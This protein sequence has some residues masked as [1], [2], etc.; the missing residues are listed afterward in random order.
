MD[1]RTYHRLVSSCI[2][3]FLTVLG[4]LLDRWAEG[5][6]VRWKESAGGEEG[7][8]V[9]GRAHSQVEDHQD[10]RQLFE[11]DMAAFLREEG[12]SQ[13]DFIEVI[14]RAH[15]EGAPG[16]ESLGSLVIE[17][18]KAIDD[19][20]SFANFMDNA[21]ASSDDGDDDFG[22]SREEKDGLRCRQESK[23]SEHDPDSQEEC[24]GSAPRRKRK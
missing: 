19:F 18:M 2:D 3:H 9:H 7:V 17:T 10:F 12:C 11:D 8:E 15:A 20:E 21:T 6:T 23:D 16:T 22:C 1:D 4:P 14:R 13:A 24:S 5:K